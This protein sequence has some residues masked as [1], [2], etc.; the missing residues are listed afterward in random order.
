VAAPDRAKPFVKDLASNRAAFHNYVIV[1]RLEAGIVLAGTEVKSLRQGSCSLKD[2]YARVKDGEVYLYNCHIPPYVHGNVFNHE[3][4]RPRKLL[5]HRNQ[6]LRLRREQEAAGQTLVPLR[7]Y[8]KEGIVKVE[9]GI[10]R[11]KKLHDKRE[12]KRLETLKREAA[13]AVRERGR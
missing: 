7:V 2:A 3:P 5:L 4:L 10:A 9:L 1:D 11:G 6:I 8:L 12:A 13:Q